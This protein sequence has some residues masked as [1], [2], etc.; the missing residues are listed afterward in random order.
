MS[1]VSAPGVTSES[2][3]SQV[4][5]AEVSSEYDISEVSAARE[6]LSPLFVN[7]RLQEFMT[8]KKIYGKFAYRNVYII[9]AHK[10]GCACLEC[11]LCYTFLH[12]I[13]LIID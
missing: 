2:V 12:A 10:S 6:A 13:I 5:V 1:Q 3:I 7:S 11:L 4:S 9:D 8:R